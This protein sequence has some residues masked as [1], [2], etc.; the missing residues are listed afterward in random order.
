MKVVLIL[1]D[2]MRPDAITNV[3][4]AQELIKRSAS[5]MTAQTVF[6]SV[7][8][9]CHLSLFH[10]VD[11]S[12]HGT[13]GNVYAPQVRPINGLC[14]V[15]KSNMKKSAF[16]Y[17]WEQLRDLSRP[18][19]LAFSYYCCPTVHTYRKSNEML[20]SAAVEYL[21]NNETDFAF[22]YLGETDFA[23]HSFGWM[24]DKYMDSIQ[25]SWVLIDKIVSELSGDYTFIV[26]A[27]HGGHDRT[28]G[29]NRPEDMTIP[30]IA[31]GKDFKAGSNLENA[32]IKDIAPTVT[33][34]LGIE[35][36]G[37]WEGKSL[38]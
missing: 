2:G 12:R 34:L 27:D 35:Q 30:I 28:H 13:T 20:S 19:S 18:G 8:L 23:G 9:P 5:S 16:F 22:I 3:K 7:T 24:S 21:L 29:E 6:P 33:K 25:R 31:C 37:D 32:N 10:S 17:N 36:D 15:I 4:E 14:E 11:P 26:T 1:A 38:F